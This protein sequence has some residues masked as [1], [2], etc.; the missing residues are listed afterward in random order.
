MLCGI[1]YTGECAKTA[2]PIKMPFGGSDL[3]KEPYVLCDP[4]P[5]WE[6]SLLG[7]FWPIVI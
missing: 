5:A 7:T 6:E 2:E 3:Y 4:D 1:S